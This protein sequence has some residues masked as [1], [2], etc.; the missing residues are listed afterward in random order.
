MKIKY[1][2][3]FLALTLSL[4][5]CGGPSKASDAS[6]AQP[7]LSSITEDTGFQAVADQFMYF[8]AYHQTNFSMESGNIDPPTF[9]K[10]VDDALANKV[11]K[12]SGD[13]L[14]QGYTD[15]VQLVESLKRWAERDHYAFSQSKVEEGVKDALNHTKISDSKRAQ[16][17]NDFKAALG[18]AYIHAVI[19]KGDGY[20]LLPSTGGI[21]FK[22]D[23]IK[24][25]SVLQ[26]EVAYRQDKPGFGQK[27]DSDQEI[28]S[29]SES[30]VTLKIETLLRDGTVVIPAQEKG[31]VYPVKGLL[32]GLKAAVLQMPEGATWT[33]IV[34]PSLAYGNNQVDGI[35]PSSTLV[36][37]VT[38]EKVE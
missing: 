20:K 37:K 22:D 7:T 3:L 24:S 13:D 10:G 29:R 17:I 35:A 1:A 30:Q 28:R 4:S 33:I 11:E 31:K 23:K 5:A 8:A 15:G 26:D 18:K 9:Q 36:F 6:P 27:P 21:A 38:L 25:L 2:P 14:K 12:N 19:R 34:P 16:I 32:P